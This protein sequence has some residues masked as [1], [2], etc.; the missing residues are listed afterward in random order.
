MNTYQIPH[1]IAGEKDKRLVWNQAVIIYMSVTFSLLSTIVFD[2]AIAISSIQ[3]SL[4]VHY[5][6]IA[7]IQHS[8]A[9]M[10]IKSY[11]NK[12]W[13][14]Y[15]EVWKEKFNHWYW[16][17]LVKLW[18]YNIRNKT[19]MYFRGPSLLIWELDKHTTSQYISAVWSLSASFSFITIIIGESNCSKWKT[20]KTMLEI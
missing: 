13:G 1:L 5:M 6:F 14:K 16:Q 20:V 19:F 3:F 10:I 2:F 8:M 9:D 15:D 4:T 17:Y 7:I 18:K 12:V 11:T